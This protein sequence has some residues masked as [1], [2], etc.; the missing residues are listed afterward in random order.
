MTILQSTYTVTVAYVV[1]EDS[2][3]KQFVYAPYNFSMITITSL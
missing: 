3:L 1:F 2:N